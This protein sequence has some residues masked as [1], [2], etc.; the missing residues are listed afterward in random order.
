MGPRMFHHQFYVSDFFF[1]VGVKGEVWGIFPGYVGKITEMMIQT[2][3]FRFVGTFLRG[4]LF[5]FHN[6]PFKVNMEGNGGLP[7]RW[8]SFSNRWF[9]GEPAVNFQECS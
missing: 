2:C 1:F 7:L 6:V 3:L 5:N 8:F 4:E 9:L